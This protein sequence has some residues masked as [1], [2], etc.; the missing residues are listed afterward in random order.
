MLFSR[1]HILELNRA[2]GQFILTYDGYKTGLLSIRLAHLSLHRPAFEIVGHSESCL[3]KPL[4]RPKRPCYGGVPER[5]NEHIYMWRSRLGYLL[6]SA[7]QEDPLHPGSKPHSGNGLLG[8]NL[9]G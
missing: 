6:G 7:C 3:P 1:L 5:N 9:F 4:A 8:T 2:S